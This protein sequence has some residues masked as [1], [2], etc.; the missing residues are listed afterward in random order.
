MRCIVFGLRRTFC[1][2]QTQTNRKSHKQKDPSL[3]LRAFYVYGA[4]GRIRTSDRLV[5]SQVLYPAE[6]RAR[7]C[8][9]EY[10]GLTTRLARNF[11]KFFMVQAQLFFLSQNYAATDRNGEPFP[12][13]SHKTDRVR[14]VPHHPNRLEQIRPRYPSI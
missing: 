4:L 14:W 6:L 13:H 9:R 2:G 11:S 12:V 7:R 1:V 10:E 5:H 8:G 3:S